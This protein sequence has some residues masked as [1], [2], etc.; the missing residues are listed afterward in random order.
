MSDAKQRVEHAIR[1]K[2]VMA[3]AELADALDL[4]RQY[5]HMLTQQLRREG[6]IA[7]VGKT[8][9]ARHVWVEKSK[10]LE[11]E[12]F[13][14]RSISLR[15]KN[16]GL[17]ED[18]VFAR[19]E[20]ETGIFL[21]VE[22]HVRQN[23][24]YAFTEMLNNAIDHSGS[25]RIDID[26][27][28][29]EDAIVFRIRDF[30]IGIFNNVRTRR[31]LDTDTEAIQDLLKGKLTTMPKIH[32]GEGVF[33]TS[34][35]VDVFAV[36]SGRTRLEVN[37]EL[38]DVSIRPHRGKEVRGTLVTCVIKLATP[39]RVADVFDAYSTAH[40]DG[41]GFNRTKI[42]VKL[43]QLGVELLSRSEAKR[44]LANLEPFKEIEFDY[45][46][47]E[48]ISQAF[49]DEI[50][51]VWASEHSDVRMTSVNTNDVIRL[52]IARVGGA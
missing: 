32:T 31:Q 50:Y 2:G 9:Q 41:S 15:L 11:R 46:D 45:Q 4:T 35:I 26:V 25:E 21:G 38:P 17:A 27:R 51:R 19:V 52:M 37:N 42:T 24:R 13:S 14:V 5:V 47:V 16:I 23:A 8:N 39:R 7:T 30:G 34:K 18:L 3:T 12:M 49:A 20:K 48:T 22:K 33:F 10:L 29:G 44:V 36:D 28:R 1:K 43:Y 6:K 40:D